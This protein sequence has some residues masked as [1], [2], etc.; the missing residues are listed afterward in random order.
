[1][2]TAR[3]TTIRMIVMLIGVGILFGAVFGFG[4]FKNYMIGKFLAGFANQTQTVA[5]VRAE[6]TLWQPA[7]SSVGSIVAVN[8]AN[9]SA[10][11]S[12][13]V[14]SIHFESGADVPAGALLVT[15]R[16]NNDPAVL[17]QL[18]AQAA[19]DQITYTR[20]VKQ[21]QADAIAQAQVDTRPRQSCGRTG[22]GAGAGG[23]DG[24][25]IDPRAVR[26]KAWHKA[27]RCRAISHR[28]H[29]DR[30]PAAAQPALCRFLPA[31]A[32]AQPARGRPERR[33]L[34]SMPFPARIFRQKFP[35]SMRWSTARPAAC[36]C[37]RHCPTIN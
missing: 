3:T 33:I 10:E 16:P 32:G 5:T 17:A 29:A 4:T 24:G 25:E 18:Q 7:L 37:A 26:R 20:D 1:M 22:A 12:G 27:G 11:I 19:L 6:E 30:D 13:I 21:F 14:D 8:G 28:R 35:R 36:R 15:L 31:A 9:L 23:A 34:R 2:S